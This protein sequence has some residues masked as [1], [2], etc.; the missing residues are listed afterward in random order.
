MKTIFKYLRPKALQ[1]GIEMTIKFTGT[2]IELLLP[3]MLSVILDVYVPKGDIKA[4]F[5]WGILM[6][7]CTAAALIT[8]VTANRMSTRIARDITTNIRG[9]LFA[10]ITTLSASQEDAFTTSSLISRLTSDTYNLHQLVDRMQR[11]GVRAP[12]LLIGGIAITFALEPVLTLVLATTLPLLALLVILVSRF[13][14]KLYALSQKKTDEMVRCAKE[15]MSGV[16]VIRALSKTKYETDRF[17]KINASISSR[18]QKAGFL[19]NAT[20]PIV[21]LLLNIGLTLVI[22]VG[23]F[24]VNNGLTQTGTIIAFLSYFTMILTAL[25]MVSRLFV[26]YSKGV[27]SGRRIAEVLDAPVEITAE[28]DC[29]PVYRSDNHID[30]ENVTFSYDKVSNNLN[31]ISFSL[32]RGQTLGIIGPTGCGKSTVLHLLL[33][34]YDTD[35][36]NIFIDGQ[37]IRTIPLH[38]LYSLFGVVF[39]NDFIFSDTIAAN[40]DFGRNLQA[41]ELLTAAELSQAEFISQRENK[42]EAQLSSKGVNLS[43]GQRQRLLIAR[44]VAAKPDI[45]LLDDSCSALDYKTDSSLRAALKHSLK[46]TTKIFVSQRVNSIMDADKILVLDD[47]CIIGYGTHKQL[48]EGCAEYQEIAKFQMEEVE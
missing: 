5:L 7:A 41:E 8:N 27:A 47:G 28:P 3:W 10:K 48:M 1:M 25:M 17:D 2:V 32:K 36:G 44:A 37:N 40:I 20:N 4:I 34:S 21:N 39:Q 29:Q 15:S 46:N 6:I 14:V 23:A 38:K 26:M 42:M 13:G 9:D 30:F 33:R 43:G 24:R 11:L 31:N 35:S 16:R 45:L 19:M 22:A 18:E 12:I